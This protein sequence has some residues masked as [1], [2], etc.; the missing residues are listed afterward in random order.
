MNM[1]LVMS[2]LLTSDFEIIDEIGHNGR[3][4]WTLVESMKGGFEVTIRKKN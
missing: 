2:I 3:Y 1:K 4:L